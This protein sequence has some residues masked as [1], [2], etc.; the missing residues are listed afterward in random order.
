[1]SP[2]IESRFITSALLLT[3]SL[4]PAARAQAPAA[5]SQPPARTSGDSILHKRYQAAQKFQA[6]N[7]LDHAA[8]Q[9]RIFLADALGEVAIGRAEAGQYDRAEDD[10]DESLKLVPDFP[11]LQLEYARAALTAGQ[12]EHASLLARALLASPSANQKIQT[13]AHALLGRALLKLDKDSEARAQFEAA[14][15]LDPTFDNGYQLGIA[16]LNLDDADAARKVFAEMLTSFGDT[17]GIHMDFGEAYNNSDFQ[18]DAVAE[19]RKAIAESPKQP[20]AHYALAVALLATGG[21]SQLHEAE[22]ELRQEI[23]NS[24]KD[25]ASYAALGH[26]LARNSPSPAEATEAEFDLKHATALDPANPDAFL[27]LGQFYAEQQRIPDAEAAL[28]Q[29]IALTLDPSRNHYQV[30][31]AHYLLGRLLVQS[32]D[33]AAADQQIAASQALME[34]SRNHDQSR[35]SDYLQEKKPS[36]MGADLAPSAQPTPAKPPA[37]HKSSAAVEAF[38]K[39]ITPA[40]ADSYNNLG[41]IAASQQRYPAALTYFARAAEWQPAL[42]GLDFNWGRAAF[43]AGAYSQAI[44]PLSRYLKANPA[45]DGARRV[46]GI[47]LFLTH[48]FRAARTTLAPLANNPAEAPLLQFA[49]ADSLVKTGDAADAIPRLEALAKTTPTLPD[50]PAALSEARAAAH[51]VNPN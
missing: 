51:P 10:F 14:V 40:V 20:G 25:A 46:L 23:A 31:K 22:D 19:F 44:G 34:Q 33:K 45:E 32:G 6:A 43:E 7:D 50:L 11:M 35:L 28:R 26:L 48:D 2:R 42:P 9:Y 29:S 3:A 16:D 24:P 4:A 12:A 41:A 21:N 18:S 1:M 30:Q 38:E 37:A 5:G 17:P 39:Q 15:A 8:E 27:Y 36:G 49:Y 13:E 47:S